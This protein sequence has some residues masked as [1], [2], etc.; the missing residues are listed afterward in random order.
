[1]SLGES[2]DCSLN[3]RAVFVTQ[4]ELVETVRRGLAA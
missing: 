3:C 2:F 4:G 1:M